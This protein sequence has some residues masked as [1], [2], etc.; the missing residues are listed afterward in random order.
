MT[1]TLQCYKC[2]SI[3]TTNADG[4][5]VDTMKS[6]CCNDWL[7]KIGQVITYWISSNEGKK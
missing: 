3:W 7:I 5:I 2:K 1:Q 4:N 6:L